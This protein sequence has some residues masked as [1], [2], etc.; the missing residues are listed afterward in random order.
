M[1]FPESVMLID[2]YECLKLLQ[3]KKV[4]CCRI[5][6]HDCVLDS[7][8]TYKYIYLNDHMNYE[9]Q[10]AIYDQ[11]ASIVQEA[12]NN[13]IRCIIS[14]SHLLSRLLDIFYRYLEIKLDIF[15][16]NEEKTIDNFLNVNINCHE[17][18][19]FTNKL[20]DNLYLI[21]DY[22]SY[23]LEHRKINHCFIMYEKNHHE[24]YLEKILDHN[25]TR[26]NKLYMIESSY[27]MFVYSI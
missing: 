1:N 8:K 9:A 21:L 13:Q 23:L 5:N 26:Y 2:Y 18:W 25:I 7:D 10:H 11:L 4:T 15:E 27:Y 3:S 17:L 24:I 16:N 22:V 14:N 20:H 6:S 19:L 12:N